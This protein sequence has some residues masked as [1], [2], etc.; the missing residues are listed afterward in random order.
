MNEN[1]LME[2]PFALFDDLMKIDDKQ[3]KLAKTEIKGIM[4]SIINSDDYLR[5]IG[6]AYLDN[7]SKVKGEYKKYQKYLKQAQDKEFSDDKNEL[8]E[9]FLTHMLASFDEAMEFGGAFRKIP[10]RVVKLTNKAILPKYQTN[11]D[12]GADIYAAEHI[13]IAPGEKAIV[14][15]GIKVVIP[16]GYCIKIVPRSGLSL[17]ENI[18]IANAPGTIDSGYR[19]EVGV[20]VHNYG[21]EPFKVTE[22]MRIAQMVLE[23]VPKIVWVEITEDEFNAFS[24]DRGMGFGSSGT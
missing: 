9:Y 2:N 24:T 15:T 21:S 1:T 22:G 5:F 17:K 7:P 12:A 11:G 6:E 16:G 4:D 19:G 3:V 10:V 23:E 13:E 18:S 8:I 14:K 20:I